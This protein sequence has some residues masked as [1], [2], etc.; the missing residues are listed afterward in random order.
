MQAHCYAY[1]TRDLAYV[2]CAWPLAAAAVQG[3]GIQ[4]F[5]DRTD[6]DVA[7]LFGD[8]AAAVVLEATP[9]N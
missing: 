2:A 9:V 1:A 6:R 8:G 4:P 5:V 3:G 7:V